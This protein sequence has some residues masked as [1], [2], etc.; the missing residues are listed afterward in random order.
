M[1]RGCPTFTLDTKLATEGLVAMVT[2][3][4]SWLDSVLFRILRNCTV[5]AEKEPQPL[6]SKH[7]SV[8]E[9]TKD[10]QEQ[11]PCASHMELNP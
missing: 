4:V 3:S 2:S 7:H 10:A 5:L 6:S 8:T 9:E 11:T 1:G